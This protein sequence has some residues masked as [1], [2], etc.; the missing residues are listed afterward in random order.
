ML[1]HALYRNTAL[2]QL[3]AWTGAWGLSFLVV[4]VNAALLLSWRKRTPTFVV[5]ATLVVV[6]VG[7]WGNE[8]RLQLERASENA[9]QLRVALVQPNIPQRLKNDPTQLNALRQRYRTLLEGVERP[10]DAVALPESI[11]PTLVLDDAATVSMLKDVT[12]RQRASVLFGAFTRKASSVFNSAVLFDPNGQTVG[13]Y[14]KVQLVPF[15]T[16]YFPLL[17]RLKQ[18]GIERW[19]GTLPLGLLTRGARFSPLSYG[20]ASFG[21]PICFESAFGRV[22][23]AFVRNGANV[24]VTITNDAWFKDSVEL[25]QHFAMGVFRVVET[26]RAFLQ[27]A[28]SGISGLILPGG[29]VAL[30]ME[31]RTAQVANVSVPLLDA[32]TPYVVWGD[33]L[34]GLSLLLLAGV[35]GGFSLH[36]LRYNHKNRPSDIRPR[37]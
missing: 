7:V 18:T 36:N 29:R 6:L 1:G 20:Q 30:E 5:L 26:G 27:V 32:Q 9:P 12:Q 17:E 14:N 8:Q 33:W 25:K 2:L 22:S 23:R 34:V 31:P 24:L 19:L 13:Q 35:G 3:A 11:L 16:E 10:V 4:F 28:N 21:T 37:A 15:S